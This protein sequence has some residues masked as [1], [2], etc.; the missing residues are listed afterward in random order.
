MRAALVP[1]ML[2]GLRS[3]ALTV[4]E[5]LRHFWRCLPPSTAARRSKLGRVAR[6]LEDVNRHCDAML[7]AS[8]G[9]DRAHVSKLLK[10][11]R[12]AMDAAFYRYDAIK[13]ALPSA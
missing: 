11:L 3:Q 2:A 10:P 7:A 9:T 12:N 6:A 1:G 13:A 8:Q 5:L 4:N